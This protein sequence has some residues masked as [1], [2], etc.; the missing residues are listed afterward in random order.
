LRRSAPRD[1]D[2][3][4]RRKRDDIHFHRCL[5]CGA[6]GERSGYWLGTGD[7]RRTTE[8]SPGE[9]ALR[10]ARRINGRQLT[11]AL[12]IAAFVILVVLSLA[13]EPT[14]LP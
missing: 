2:E 9:D 13:F 11:V 3:K 8:P 12:I 14:P 6:R 10:A 1:P 7:Q 4:R 5:D